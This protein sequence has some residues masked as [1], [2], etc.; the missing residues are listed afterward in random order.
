M[1]IKFTNLYKLI[2]DKKKIFKKIFTLIK[3]SEFL[4]GNEVLSFEKEFSKFIKTKYCISVANGTD[5]LEM[6]IKSLN[7]KNNSEIIVPNNTWIS[8]AEAVV[9]NNHKV[10]LCDINLDDYT[11]CLNDLKNKITSKTRAIIIVHLYGNPANIE[12][13]RKIIGGKKIKLIEDCAQA[14]GSLINN[15]HVGTFGDVSCFS[16]FPSKNLGAFGDAGAI[17]T[18]NKKIFDFCL[19][20]KNHGSL[21]KYDH[22]FLGR[23]SRLDSIQ[24]AVLRIK[25]KSYLEV[26][27]R[28]KYLSEIY[29]KELR[30]I[31]T[32]KLFR[33]KN[34]NQSSF[35][36][37]VI[38]LNSGRNKLKSYLNKFGIETMIHYPYML[39]DLKFFGKKNIL[40]NS[41][42]LGNK[43]L[44]L[45][46]SEDHTAK[47]IYYICKKIKELTRKQL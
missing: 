18:N 47:E 22:K 46:I 41:N 6:A 9:A 8:T 13:V 15:R 27:K 36:Q 39:N 29:F 11:I 43:I 42:N 14:H 30:N 7:L 4:G 23:N 3:N 32:I 31:S 19:R 20:Y 25:L 26:I 16:F 38:R 2:K 10:V 12:G 44:S 28:R 34:K 5:A 35:H 1:K 33:L 21:K 17:V 37:F 45:P 40:T 24:S